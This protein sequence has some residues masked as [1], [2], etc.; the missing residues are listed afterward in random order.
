MK[1]EIGARGGNRTRT[2]F[3]ETDFKS[4]ASTSSAT[5]AMPLQELEARNGIEY[6]PETSFLR[7]FRVTRLAMYPRNYANRFAPGMA[8]QFIST[9]QHFPQTILFQNIP[10]P[11]V[12]DW[13]AHPRIGKY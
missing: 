2:R 5:R 3:R 11:C 4:V 9:Q 8:P 6:R 10:V 1:N 12:D 13:Q 7:Y